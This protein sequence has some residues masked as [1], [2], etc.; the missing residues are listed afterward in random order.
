MTVTVY[1]STDSSA[2]SLTGQSGSLITLLDA[3]LVNGYGVKPAAGWAKA[4]TGTNKAVYQPPVIAASPSEGIRPFLRVDD[5]YATTNYADIRGF[6]TMSSVDTGEGQFPRRPLFALWRK[7]STTNG[8]AR[9]WTI[10]AT[11]RAFYLFFACNQTVYGNTDSA[12]QIAF[13]GEFRPRFNGDTGCAMLAGRADTGVDYFGVS[14]GDSN[15]AAVNMWLML[16]HFGHT[17]GTK[18]SLSDRRWNLGIGTLGQNGNGPQWPDPVTGALIISRILINEQWN[19]V[20]SASDR[21]IRGHMPGAFAIENGSYPGSMYDTFDGSG[22]FAGKT[23]LIVPVYNTT[24][25]GRILI[26]LSD[27]WWD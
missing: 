11:P 24:T 1:R 7:S 9:P 23:F 18:A 6:K 22:V 27:T 16:G 13:F 10:I 12:D 17:S 15:L 21:M 19:A 20:E 3:V 26:D 2:P 25:Q 5:S 14:D 8:T 4:F